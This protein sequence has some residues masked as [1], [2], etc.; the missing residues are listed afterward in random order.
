MHIIVRLLV[1]LPYI[2]C[3]LN[4]FKLLHHLFLG[5]QIENILHV[6]EKN[7]FKY[8]ETMSKHIYR[9]CIIGRKY[10]N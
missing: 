8:S 5:Y 1:H 4:R 7:K 6:E 2:V 9:S 3:S 10:I